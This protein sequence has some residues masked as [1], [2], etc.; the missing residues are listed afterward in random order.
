MRWARCVQ[1]DGRYPVIIYAPGFSSTSWENADLCEY[2]ASYG[3]VV[4]ASPSMGATSRTMT[5]DLAGIDAQCRDISFLLGFACGL[6]NA[7]TSRVA[8]AGFSW[9]GISNLFAA[10]RDNRIKALIALD[11]SLRAYPGLVKQAGDVRPEQMTIPLLYFAQ[12]Y[13]SNEELDRYL[14][15]AEKDGPNVLNAWMHG[16]LI[17]VHMMQLSHPEF[18]SMYQRNED[19]WW[20][21][22]HVWAHMKADYGARTALPDTPG[23]PATRCSFWM[24][25]LRP[26]RW[27]GR[28]CRKRPR[29]TACPSVITVN[30]RAAAGPSV[31]FDRF[32]MEVGRQGFDYLS[33][34]YATMRKERSEF[35]LAEDDVDGWALDLL[36]AEHLPEAITLLKFNVEM[37]PGSGAAD[38]SL[39][40]AYQM[41]GDRQSAMDSYH[42]ALGKDPMNADARLKLSKLAD[43]TSNDRTNRKPTA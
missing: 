3:Y 4:I 8:V 41:R 37:H 18:S 31:S 28:F 17:N 24:P 23:W 14:T 43:S 12:R 22:F 26:M 1:R 33:E 42:R 36:D 6:S 16:D 2:L 13:F 27:Q 30:Y 39:G 9:G 5:R 19:M 25:T 7:D 32:R 35:K 20:K 15:D 38:T 29:K 21:I 34:I 11:G 10:A 40:T